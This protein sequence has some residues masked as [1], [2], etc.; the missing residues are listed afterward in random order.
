L[1]ILVNNACKDISKPLGE[2]TL[3]EWKRAFDTKV[4]GAWLCTKYALPLLKKS[5]NANVMMISS[6]ADEKPSA[7]VLSYATATAALN[8]MIK[9][10]A[11]HLPPFGIRVNAV[12]AGPTRTDNWEELKK[13][14]AFWKTMAE[15]NPMKRVGTVEE[16]AEAVL[17]LVN[18]PHKFLNG[19][20]LFVD[21]GSNWV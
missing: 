11:V 13:D 2:S 4:H 8:A 5:E 12:M 17:Y 10:W 7:N 18:D 14:D 1:D 20:F 9:A 19:N 21:G 15:R 3:E 16:V 6:T